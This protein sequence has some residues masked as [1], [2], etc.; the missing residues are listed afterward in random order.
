LTRTNLSKRLKT[1]WSSRGTSNSNTDAI[2]DLKSKT[3]ASKTQAV[4]SEAEFQE[5]EQVMQRASMTEKKEIDRIKY[6]I[7]LTLEFCSFF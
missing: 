4:I 7:H 3:N 2:S 1:G 6:E 5:I